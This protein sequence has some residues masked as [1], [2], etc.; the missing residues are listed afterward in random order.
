[1]RIISSLLYIPN[2]QKPK[3]ILF[4]VKPNITINTDQKF[5]DK[6]VTCSII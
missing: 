3:V 4:I 6:L 2:F 1:M 5:V